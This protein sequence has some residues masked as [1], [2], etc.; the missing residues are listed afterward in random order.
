[1]NNHKEAQGKVKLELMDWKKLE[2]DSKEALRQ[3]MTI[4][5]IHELTLKKAQEEISKYDKKGKKIKDG[6]GDEPQA[7]NR[8]C[9][10]IWALTNSGCDPHDN[11]AYKSAPGITHEGP[12]FAIMNRRK[13]EMQ[14][15]Q[16]RSSRDH[17]CPRHW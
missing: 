15:S 12:H 13:I 2:S 14:K 1:M 6:H 4:T 10:R 8:C 9:D 11:Q 16:Y 17:C 7:N 3:V 5:I